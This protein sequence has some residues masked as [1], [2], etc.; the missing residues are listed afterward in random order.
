[1]VKTSR[2]IETEGNFLNW[3][4]GMTA[5]IT[6]DSKIL[7]IGSKARCSLSTLL[8]NIMLEVLSIQPIACILGHLSS[9]MFIAALFLIAKNLISFSE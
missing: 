8:F 9:R 5:D 7:K 6:H 4:K 1:M 3:R 2:T